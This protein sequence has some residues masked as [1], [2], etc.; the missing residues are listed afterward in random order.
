MAKYLLGLLQSYFSKEF[1]SPFVLDAG[2]WDLVLTNTDNKKFVFRGSLCP[3]V[4]A[5]TDISE[6]FRE[7]LRMP[8]LFMFDGQESP[9]QIEEIKINYNRI[10]NM[11]V[12][13]VEL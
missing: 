6:E 1:D 9:D 5:L 12:C 10:T 2:S 7:N 4:D 8:D 11:G 13:Y 3:I